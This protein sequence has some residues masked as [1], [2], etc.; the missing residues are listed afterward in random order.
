MTNQEEM[1][2]KKK[3]QLNYV[4]LL[5]KQ[6]GRQPDGQVGLGLS[7]KPAAYILFLYSM[8]CCYWSGFAGLFIPHNHTSKPL[9][10][11]N[12]LGSY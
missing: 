12:P 2:A 1:D 3:E 11:W 5:G 10:F 4:H 7:L 8:Y 6:A 9:K